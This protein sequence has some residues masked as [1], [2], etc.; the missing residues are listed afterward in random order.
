MVAY[1]LKKRSGPTL[2][3]NTRSTLDHQPS[4]ERMTIMATD[5]S[6]TVRQEAPH[7][8]RTTRT[9]TIINALKRRARAVL[10]DSSIDPQ[11]RAIV[12]Y[13]LEI[14]DPWLAEL[15]RRAD[16][17]EALFDTVDFSQTP[18]TSE[19]DSSNERVEALAEMICCAGD[20][21]ETKSAALL[22]LMATIE[23][24]AHPKALANTAKHL[25]FTRCGEL[26]LYG[27]VEAQVA[28]VEH[29][30]FANVV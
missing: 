21:P 13:A 29:E 14:N 27:M 19:H 28:T 10:N 2:C 16:D 30:L 20:D 8:N 23:N 15:V 18:G 6:A 9:A 7:V 26:N 12:R 11:S 25:A 4:E 24:S 17:G 5:T 3:A 22:V 1:P